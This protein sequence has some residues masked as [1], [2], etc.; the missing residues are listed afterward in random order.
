MNPEYFS[1]PAIS[2][3]NYLPLVPDSHIWK[4]GPEDLLQQSQMFWHFLIHLIPMYQFSRSIHRFHFGSDE[5]YQSDSE[6]VSQQLL[7]PLLFDGFFHRV[8]SIDLN[9]D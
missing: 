3:I 6:I 7:Y 9:S 8:L 5:Y 4:S 1:F 2:L